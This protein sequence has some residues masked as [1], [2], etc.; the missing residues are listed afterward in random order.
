MAHKTKP[1][2]P[3]PKPKPHKKP[4]PDSPYEI[5]HE[6]R[7]LVREML[8]ILKGHGKPDGLTPG[9]IAEFKEIALS[10]Q[11]VTDRLNAADRLT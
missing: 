6:T 4:G 5:M 2:K 7:A 9:Q 8:C 1:P 11:G 10:L 3:A